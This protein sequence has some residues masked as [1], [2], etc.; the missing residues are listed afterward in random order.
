M[1]VRMLTV[2]VMLSLALASARGADPTGT[3]TCT[4]NVPPS[5]CSA[6]S[7]GFQL[8]QM[9][10]LLRAVDFIIADPE[11]FKQMK[12]GA[13]DVVIIKAANLQGY[14]PMRHSSFDSEILFE[15]AKAG[16]VR[17]PDRIVISTDLFRPVKKAV[18]KKPTSTKQTSS[19]Q[20]PVEF[21]EGYDTTTSEE[22][23]MFIQGYIEGCRNAKQAGE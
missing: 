2:I 10:P 9:F 16:P 17:C 19:N 20:A 21:S 3:V 8:M 13:V 5:T 6:A 18:P 14:I 4:S 11:A 12:Q 22:Y 23:Q 7:V 1:I 15:M